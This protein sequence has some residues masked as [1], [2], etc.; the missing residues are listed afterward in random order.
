MKQPLKKFDL[1]YKRAL[2]T[3]KVNPQAVS[4]GTA[5]ASGR[6]SVRTVFLKRYD[7]RGFIFYTNYASRK[8]KEL[9]KNPQAALLFYW[10]SLSRQVR[11]V[12]RTKR[13]SRKESKAYF[14]TRSRESQLGAW[15]SA[16]SAAIP[17]RAALLKK[18]AAFEKRFK[19]K[20]VPLPP[21]WGGICIVPAEIEF[22]QEGAHRLHDRIVYRKIK[23][24]WKEIRLAP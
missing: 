7:E 9:S 13:V 11:I 19:G 17:H 2:R 14:R 24:K 16:Q 12:G 1:W 21:S 23:G 10:K 22:W 4:L 6:P 5:S 3:E 8:G 15:A 18:V 20:E